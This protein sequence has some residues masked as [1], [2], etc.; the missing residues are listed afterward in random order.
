MLYLLLL[1]LS[2]CAGGAVVATQDL[3]IT[4]L[5]IDPNPLSGDAP[6]GALLRADNVVL[7]RKGTAEPRPGF[8]VLDTFVG[9]SKMYGLIPFDGGY[10]GVGEFI[11]VNTTFWNTGG[12]G[13]TDGSGAL[14]WDRD[15]IRSCAAR[16]NL[17]ITTS[18]AVRKLTGATDE[19]AARAGLGTVTAYAEP[20]GAGSAVPAN[21][22]VA[23]RS[24]MRRRDTNGLVLRGEP[25]GRVIFQNTTGAGVTTTVTVFLHEREEYEAGDVVEIYRTR[26][27]TV[28]PRDEM[29]L[30][31]ERELVDADIVTGYISVAD[32]RLDADLGA[33]LYTNSSRE[34]V[35]RS[36]V[37][38]PLGTD[39]A[40]YAGSMFASR[41]TWPHR[42]LLRW[43]EG[44]NLSGI[45]TGVGSRTYTG[46]RTNGSNQITGL[47]STVGL[48]VG[49]TAEAAGWNGTA[50]LRITAIVGTTLTMSETWAGAT[51]GAPASLSF[52]D[53]IRISDGAQDLYFRSDVAVYLL[54]D[55]STSFTGRATR[56]TTT[57]AYGVGDAQHVSSTGPVSGLRRSVVIERLLP[58]ASSFQ[59]WATHGSEYDPPLPEPTVVAGETSTQD[60]FPNGVSWSKTDQPE[61]FMRAS[62][63]LVGREDVPVLRILPAGDALW[64]LKGKGDGIYRLAGFGERSG[65]RVDQRSASTYLLHPQLA[66]VLGDAVYAWTSAGAVEI[67]DRGII[68]LSESPLG[69]EFAD[70]QVAL[71]HSAVAPGAFAVAS[72]KDGEIIFGLPPDDFADDENDGRATR[73]Y[74]LNTETRAWSRW[75]HELEYENQ[76]SCAMYDPSSRLLSFGRGGAGETRVE[77]GPDENFVRHA[78]VERVVTIQDV[79]DDT[80]TIAGGSGWTPAEG[81]LIR[82]GSTYAI[83]TAVTSSTV[84]TVHSAVGFA[85]GA[86]TS[87][88][89][90]DAA[91]EWL[92]KTGEAPSVLK[93]FR[94][95]VT[96]WEDTYGV[97]AWSMGFEPLKFGS[98][99]TSSYTRAYTR[100]PDSADDIRSHVP[101]D[102]AL[103]SRLGL[104][105]NI[106]QADARWRLAG[107]TVEIE[108][109]GARIAR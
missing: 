26:S 90:F 48:L 3:G 105:L 42:M 47:S 37:R 64:I 66:T 108:P 56:L 57:R 104:T 19:I 102:A 31:Y 4:G 17:Y 75:F 84:F 46:T 92:T 67:S 29:L 76:L 6:K 23:Y 27:S 35:E 9:L 32:S 73:V 8:K 63:W 62:R 39:L 96:H 77:R 14:S 54:R 74:V 36:N 53:S 109:A 101:R 50:S 20:L 72:E 30:A 83:I 107:L 103:G 7:R 1:L 44:G 106:S 80:I 70:L 89:H 68:P 71:D 28:S 81:D 87:Y 98:A 41:V 52:Y 43:D 69:S 58:N 33:A 55:V 100:T 34:G 5:W 78:D 13:V 61:H 2:G 93:R 65:W 79:T 97:Y 88:E 60:D 51:D 95:V 86:G 24:V 21:T 10:L 15:A 85:A 45:A 94:E 16:K 38:P 40:L 91:L 11:D 18:D 22:Y 49:M 99:A 25:S 12:A 59:V 82:L